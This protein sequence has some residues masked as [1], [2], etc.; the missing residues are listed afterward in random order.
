MTIKWDQELAMIH[1]KPA[2]ALRRKAET[3]MIESPVRGSK[4]NGKIEK[5]IRSWQSQFRTMCQRLEYWL[6]KQ[7]TND[8]ALVAWLMLQVAGVISKYRVLPNGRTSYEMK[9]HHACKHNI[10]GFGEEAAYA[11]HDEDAYGRQGCH[12]DGQ[13]RRRILRWDLQPEHV[14]LDFHPGQ[15]CGMLYNQAF[16]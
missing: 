16:R 10:H 11:M 7:I 1:L 6:T 8:S 12:V 15:H 2:S 9:T 5:A 13:E 4:S 3:P 14:V